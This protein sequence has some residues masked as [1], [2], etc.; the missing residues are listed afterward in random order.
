MAR[1]KTADTL[2]FN[3]E[4]KHATGDKFHRFLKGTVVKFED[5]D[6]VNYFTN[7]G[8]ADTSDDEPQLTL[9]K[10]ELDID[11]ETVQNATG[12]KVQ[13]IITQSEG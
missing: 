1:A 9:T 13:D 5:P 7:F 12:L 3:Q 6:A 10:E 4:V 8:W 2:K 11:P